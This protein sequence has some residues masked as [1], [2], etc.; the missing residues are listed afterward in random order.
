MA[1]SLGTPDSLPDDGNLL[2]EFEYT[3]SFS[4]N[5]GLYRSSPY[6]L[7]EASMEPDHQSVL[8]VTQLEKLGARHV[9]P[10]VDE[11]A[12]KVKQHRRDLVW[13]SPLAC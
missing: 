11:P 5:S 9:L 6:V 4:P 3:G 13:T 12:A 10:C 1:I 8:I 7:P 2:L